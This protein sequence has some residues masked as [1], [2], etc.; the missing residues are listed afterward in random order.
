MDPFSA[1]K[2]A[3]KK[4]Y[5][6]YPLTRTKNNRNEIKTS[7]ENTSNKTYRLMEN[8]G[9]HCLPGPINLTQN[10]MTFQDQDSP[11]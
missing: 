9:K 5:K 4:R 1:N 8:D 7:Q 11:A 3:R 10:P 2:M 6:P